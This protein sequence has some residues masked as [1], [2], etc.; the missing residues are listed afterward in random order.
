MRQWATVRPAEKDDA[1]GRAGLAAE[2]QFRQASNLCVGSG[3]LREFG[4][5]NAV[6]AADAAVDLLLQER[7][8]NILGTHIDGLT[9]EVQSVHRNLAVASP[10]ANVQADPGEQVA[11]RP[12]H[13]AV[14][15]AKCEIH[16]LLRDGSGIHKRQIPV[17]DAAVIATIPGAAVF[18]RVTRSLALQA[19][20]V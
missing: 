12:L 19:H 17:V 4:F 2:I 5:D 3:P 18:L 1:R 14:W 6:Q 13:A 16:G 10:G 8:G 9:E 20:H 15:Q 7:P 11:K